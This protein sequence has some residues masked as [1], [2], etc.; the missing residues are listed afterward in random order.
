[1][2]FSAK[3]SAANFGFL[4]VYL[5]QQRFNLFGILLKCPMRAGDR[6]YIS[7]RYVLMK[8][9]PHLRELGWWML[10]EPELGS[11]VRV[12]PGRGWDNG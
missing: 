4:F 6:C 11:L 8:I 1:M 2:L 7:L 10:G 9:R 3:I 5:K 12:L